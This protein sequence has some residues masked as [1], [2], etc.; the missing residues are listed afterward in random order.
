VR[1][2]GNSAETTIT[3]LLKLF[4]F[5]EDFDDVY[6]ITYPNFRVKGILFG[7]L[8]MEI[9][10]KVTIKSLNSTYTAEIDFKT[11]GMFK[12]KYNE[13]SGAIKNKG[14]TLY[15]LHGFWDSV[16]TITPHKTKEKKVFFDPAAHPVVEKIVPPLSEQAAN[17]S[18]KLWEDVIREMLKRD[19]DQA[20]SY[21]GK[22]EAVQRAEENERKTKNIEWIPRHFKKDKDGNYLF[23]KLNEL[24]DECKKVR[25]SKYKSSKNA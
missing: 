24:L 2:Y 23:E 22:M 15:D 19:E 14:H 1:F 20:L 4:V 11:K 6:D 5:G 17:E 9:F 12:G 13:V 3:G 25:D 21:K 8:L 7:T 18:R 10:G 16:I